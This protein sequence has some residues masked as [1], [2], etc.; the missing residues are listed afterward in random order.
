MKIS[1]IAA[2]SEN[3]V[4]GSKGRIPWHIPEDLKRFKKITMGHTVIMG[5]KT[6]ESL[7]SPLTGRKNIVLSGNK[8]YRAEG[9]EVYTSIGDA[10][11]KSE[12]GGEK[13][14]FVIGGGQI[15]KKTLPLADR[16]YITLIHKEFEGDSFFPIIPES[17]FNKVFEE[18]HH[19]KKYGIDT[20]SAKE[21]NGSNN[22]S[23][24]IFDR[25]IS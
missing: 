2:I 15:F 25:V 17:R 7:K 4:I 5:R 20:D 21:K 23:F 18:N 16:I 6:Y 12:A 11:K 22:Y 14:L 19:E 8:D 10:I 9:A 24:I 13:E 3:R 1:L